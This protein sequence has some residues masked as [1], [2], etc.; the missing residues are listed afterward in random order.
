MSHN[1][2]DYEFETYTLDE[3]GQ[4]A[5]R[6]VGHARTLSVDL[7]EVDL[8]MVEIPEGSFVM[9]GPAGE[10]GRREN[11]SPQHRV[12]LPSFFLGRFPVTQAQWRAVMGSPPPMRDEFRGDDLPAVNVWWEQV[13]DFCA[14]LSERSGLNVRLPSEAEWE[15]ACRAGTS[16]P[17]HWGPTIT[18]E[19][20]NFDGTRPYG[21]AP[22]GTFRRG[23]TP[24][25]YFRAANGFG[26]EDMHG[27]VWEW[28]ADVWH[29][30]YYGAPEDG[31]AW[32]S[33]G[34]QGYI[35]QRGG[36]WRDAAVLCRAAFR[37]GD[38]AY[39]SDHIVGLRACVTRPESG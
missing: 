34:D 3:R 17:Y 22:K 35:V 20:A 13:L 4:I 2:V 9:G 39:N 30:D 11:E 27:N 26:L 16:T 1:L 6:R 33:G 32:R 29:D 36:S 21:A 37:V 19:V 38:I 15:Y 14:R 12:S 31:S 7:G 10:P 28:C 25:G 5:E 8:Q 23:L 18:S 24:A